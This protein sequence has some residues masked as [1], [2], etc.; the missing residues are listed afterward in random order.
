MRELIREAIHEH[1]FRIIQK[2]Y[3]GKRFD[4]PSGS[5]TITEVSS[6]ITIHLATE[7][8]SLSD[9]NGFKKRIQSEFKTY[10]HITEVKFLMPM[11]IRYDVSNG[12]N[13]LQNPDYIK[14]ALEKAL[15]YDNLGPIPL[16][17]IDLYI[18]DVSMMLASGYGTWK[19]QLILAINGEMKKYSMTHHNEDWYLS[20]QIAY[21]S[22]VADSE[23]EYE[24]AVA[25]YQAAFEAVVDYH[26]DEMVEIVLEQMQAVEDED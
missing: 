2:Y 24:D 10:F 5:I 16:F 20:Q 14:E 25:S 11:E 12:G 23:E 7:G 4:T 18:S 6:G 17:K 22:S 26:I 9:L 21:D 8:A 1:L 19:V 15:L 3:Q 13:P